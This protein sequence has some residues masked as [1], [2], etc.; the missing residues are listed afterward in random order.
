MGYILFFVALRSINE[1]SEQVVVA[2]DVHVPHAIHHQKL[3]AI[4]K[5]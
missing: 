1:N 5:L 2:L 4:R 3:E